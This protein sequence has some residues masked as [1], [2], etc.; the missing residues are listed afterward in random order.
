[1]ALRLQGLPNV[2]GY[3]TLNEPSR[4]YIGEKNI[5]Q[6]ATAVP[7]LMGDSPTIFQSLLSGAGYPQTVDVYK[8]G[9][10]NFKK[11]GTRMLNPQRESAWAAGREDIW[12]QHGVWGVDASGQPVIQRANYFSQVGE[13][14]VNFDEDYFKPFAN[15]FGRE[16]RSVAPDA[17]IFVEGVPSQAGL[18]WGAEDA[19]NIVHAAHWYDDLTLVK[20]TFTNWMAVDLQAM[21]LVFGPKA[22]RLN[23][24]RQIARII[25]QS[26]EQMNHAPTLIG[27]VG[28][29]FD[30]Q[31]KR[32]FRTGDF[33]MESAFLMRP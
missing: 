27:E 1:M 23:F 24:V 19:T 22:V 8:L 7:A 5:N 6:H 32:A 15:R 21:K 30:M 14:P 25:R 16:I 29:P 12:K 20:K 28:I 11:I 31:N 33:S 3:D 26:E 17:I 9:M 2:V 18:T 10:T 13:R 4:G